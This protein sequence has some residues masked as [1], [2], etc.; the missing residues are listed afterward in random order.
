MKRINNLAIF[1]IL[2]VLATVLS[3][4]RRRRSRNTYN[5]PAWV[6]KVKAAKPWFDD[7]M[8]G[9]LAA[10]LIGFYDSA[11]ELIPDDSF[12]ACFLKENINQLWL[13]ESMKMDKAIEAEV[14]DAKGLGQTLGDLVAETKFFTDLTAAY[15][16][17]TS[18]TTKISE[19]VGKIKKWWEDLQKKNKLLVFINNTAMCG[20]A[21]GVEI[22]SGAAAAA[23]SSDGW[24]GAI[25]GAATKGIEKVTLAASIA[26]MLFDVIKN[27]V[28]ALYTVLTGA[29]A[30]NEKLYQGGKFIGLAAVLFVKIAKLVTKLKKMKMMKQQMKM[31]KQKLRRFKKRYQI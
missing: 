19:V 30:I 3:V 8:K 1:V 9:K 21:A 26:T 5:V 16:N 18:L 2:L 12:T 31:M 15:P 23:I 14:P 24:W 22:V 27:Q 11:K 4:D 7:F 6:T 10:F 25:K 17:I 29:L 13:T 28:P 20:F